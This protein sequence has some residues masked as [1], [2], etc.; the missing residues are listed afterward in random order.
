MNG[1][2]QIGNAGELVRK[3]A[4]RV[5][6]DLV[7]T[8]TPAALVKRIYG[9]VLGEWSCPDCGR[10]L[11]ES[12]YPTDRCKGCA[13]PLPK[14]C[15]RP[16]CGTIVQPQVY[17]SQ[18]RPFHRLGYVDPW[19]TCG[20]CSGASGK[21]S[22]RQSVLTV[23]EE[24]VPAET[25]ELAT[26]RWEEYGWREDFVA[27]LAEWVGTD[28]GR[29]TGFSSIYIWSQVAK[30]GLKTQDPNITGYGNGKTV[31]AAYAART[32]A[33][34]HGL[35]S[36]MAWTTDKKL[37]EAHEHRYKDDKTLSQQATDLLERCRTTALLVIDELFGQPRYSAK[38]AAELGDILCERLENRRPTLFTSN[39]PPAWESIDHRLPSRW[40]AVGRVVRWEGP[41]LRKVR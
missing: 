34:T 20:P 33:V 36:S 27:A 3:M 21:D 41:D 26:S 14:R 8:L 18:R 35:V 17:Y 23:L 40:S 12:D 24:S 39:F 28:L 16:G 4:A 2:G 9:V 7:H 19:P 5:R 6:P 37:I 38:F 22:S 13:R 29:S 11:A 32:A 10:V 15:I 30:S 31:A 1:L 25:L